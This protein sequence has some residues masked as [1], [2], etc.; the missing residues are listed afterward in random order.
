MKQIFSPMRLKALLLLLLVAM[1]VLPLLAA[2][3]QEGDTPSS[4]STDTTGSGATSSEELVL[5]D[6]VRLTDHYWPEYDNYDE[7]AGMRA[8]LET[9]FVDTY[10]NG[11]AAPF[12]LTYGGIS[13]QTND[14]QNSKVG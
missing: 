14:V 7:Y 5:P 4:T 13:S 3:S 12:S 2:C 1:M 9:W 11:N 10:V 8:K 6:G